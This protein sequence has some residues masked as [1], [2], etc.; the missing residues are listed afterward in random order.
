MVVNL[1]QFGGAVLDLTEITVNISGNSKISCICV[2][3][4]KTAFFYYTTKRLT[5]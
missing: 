2:N 3:L 4:N 1:L 5:L